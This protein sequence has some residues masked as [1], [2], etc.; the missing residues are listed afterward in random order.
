MEHVEH[1]EQ[2]LLVIS[3]V[4]NEAAH[5]ESV[6]LA[7]ASQTRRPDLW[8]VVD[9]R[10][11]D[12]TPQV[13]AQLAERLDFI[14]VM[15]SPPP[16]GEGKTKDRLAV[17]A[18]PRSFNLGL[19]SVDWRSFTHVAKLDGDI[20]LPSRYFELLLGEFERDPRL[21]L[22][23][24]VLRERGGEDKAWGS[25]HAASDYHVRGALKC[26]S[27]D[28]LEAIGGIQE[29][30]GWDA[31]DEVYARM[32]GYRTRT[33]PALIALHHRPTGSADGQLRGRARH[34]QSAYIVQFTLPWVAL[35]S[36]KVARERPRGLSGIAFLY[37]YLRSALLRVPRVDDPEFRRFV[38]RELRARIRAELAERASRVRGRVSLSV[39]AS[40]RE[41]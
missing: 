38:R 29:R 16:A 36:F 13:L 37:G 2:R 8:V 17:G 23:G 1:M 6:A 9:D 21:G 24:G 26:Y 12:E 30:L 31:L 10:S 5:I 41:R 33:V 32:R 18:A 28:C 27:R 11:T 15:H 20:E 4:R 40:A 34:G 7:L 22:A 25:A 39:R 14:S 35:R 3:P 19:H